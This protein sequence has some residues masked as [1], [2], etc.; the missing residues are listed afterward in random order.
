MAVPPTGSPPADPA[1]LRRMIFGLWTTRSLYVAAELGVADQLASGPRSCEELAAACGADSSALYRVLR[2]LSGLGLF[3]ETDP[4]HF[5][6]APLGEYLRSNVPGSMRAFIRMMGASWHW[7]T[8]EGILSSVRT[9]Q[10]TTEGMGGQSLYSFLGQNPEQEQL[11]D[12]A[13][14]SFS[15][16]EHEAIRQAWD[17]TTSGTLV[18]V[19]GGRGHLLAELLGAHPG[20]RGILFDR[21]SVVAGAR[22]AIRERGLD[23]RCER[24]GGDFFESVPSGGDAYLI[25]YVLHNWDDARVS[26]ILQSCRRAMKPSARLLLVE[27]LVQPGNAPDPVRLLDV[28]MLVLVGGRERT[29]EEFRGLLAA[30]GFSLVRVVNTRLPLSIVEAAPV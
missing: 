28:E 10:P 17:F 20:L 9:G 5:A 7:R 27:Q 2:A 25:K 26:A 24:V 6:L 18:D 23:G 19:G 4:R 15:S 1:V 29:E 14:T 8:F 22:D 16:V 3:T 30:S 13:M 12:Q 11:F 21:P